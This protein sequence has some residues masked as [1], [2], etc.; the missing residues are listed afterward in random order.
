MTAP[1]K[2]VAERLAERIVEAGLAAC[3]NVVPGATSIYRWKGKIERDSEVLL[4]AKTLAPQVEK[5]AAFV[6][7]NHPY[8]LPELVALPVLS[9]SP[10][11]LK[12]VAENAA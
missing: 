6:K 1:D 12:W 4:I 8:E 11:Y 9:G 7:A 10:E 3:V 2:A 5:L